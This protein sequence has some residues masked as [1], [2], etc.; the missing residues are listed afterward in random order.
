MK[1]S[2]YQPFIFLLILLPFFLGLSNRISPSNLEESVQADNDLKDHFSKMIYIKGGKFTKNSTSNIIF[3]ESDSTLF[4]HCI[5]QRASVGSYFISSTEITNSD[6]REFYEEKVQ[7]LGKIK[8]KEKYYPDTARWLNEFKYTS[9]LPHAK[10]YFSLPNFNDYPVVGITWDQAN[11]YCQWKTEKVNKLLERKGRKSL[12]EF[13]LPTENEWEF[14]A[15]NKRNEDRSKSQTYYSWPQD[16]M[17]SQLID[18]VNLGR[19]L[20]QN[21]TVLKEYAEDGCLYPCEVASYPPNNNGIYNMSGNVSEWT[22]DQ[23]EVRTRSFYNSNYK[24]KTLTTLSEIESEIAYVRSNFNMEEEE[25][26]KLWLKDIEHDKKIISKGNVKICKGGSWA[27]GLIYAQTGSRQ[28]INKDIAS[29]KIGFRI[30][31]SDVEEEIINYFPNKK[32]K[33]SR[34]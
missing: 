22:S 26:V 21:G 27:S 20:D 25:E 33:P 10:N 18:L 17:I 5:P 28:G 11:L 32:W 14:A 24:S 3:T 29:I 12:I 13:R 34:K 23:G 19:I 2:R 7:E 30:A 9:N 8:A 16:K 1:Y 6:W 4:S 31:I 15:M